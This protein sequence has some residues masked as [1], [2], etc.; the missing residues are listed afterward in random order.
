M[1]LECEISTDID[2]VT[3]DILLQIKSQDFTR[4]KKYFSK[5]VLSVTMGYYMKTTAWIW[6][7]RNFSWSILEE[8]KRE[9]SLRR[10]PHD[11][12]YFLIILLKWEKRIY[13]LEILNKEKLKL[14]LLC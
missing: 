6:K 13:G 8:E 3:I 12:K 2:M 11:I 1:V 7:K 10:K 9:V 4:R 14:T 5:H